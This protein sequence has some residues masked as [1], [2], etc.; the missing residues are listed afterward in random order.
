MK[1]KTAFMDTY[2]KKIDKLLTKCQSQKTIIYFLIAFILL[3]IFVY[4]FILSKINLFF[5]ESS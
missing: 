2:T 4:L 3:L 1:I 5:L